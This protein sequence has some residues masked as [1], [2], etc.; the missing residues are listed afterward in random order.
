LSRADGLAAVE[1]DLK[2]ALTDLPTI[3]AGPVPQPVASRAAANAML[4]RL[5]LNKAV[6]TASAAEGP[7]TFDPADMAKVIQY[8]TA[9]MA[10]G[11]TLNT[12]YFDNFKGTGPST[13]VIL[14]SRQGSPQNRVYMTLHYNQNPSGWNGFATLADFYGKFESNDKRKGIPAGQIPGL[15]FGSKF[16]GIGL[17]FL[18]GQQKDDTGANITDT[19]TGLPLQFTPDVPLSGAA[20]NKGIRV[21]KYHPA[22]YDKYVL[23]RFGEVYLNMIEAKVRGGTHASSTTSALQDI[24]A[25]R[26]V[27]GAAPLSAVTLQDVLDERGRELYWEGLRRIDLIRFGKFNDTWNEKGPNSDAFRVLYSIPQLAI[28][29]NPNLKQN[30]GYGGK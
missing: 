29:T 19:R 1:K 28:D 18:A 11:Y 2:E 4:S 12:N 24:N 25:L 10:D 14:T 15:P 30:P 22:F 26:A 5:Y 7:Y 20:T 8:A 21:M 3:A 6:Y 16:S 27:R 13:E 23:L 9:V 17:G